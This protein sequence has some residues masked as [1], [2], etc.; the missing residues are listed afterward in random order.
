MTDNEKPLDFAAELQK[1]Y[2][3]RGKELKRSGKKITMLVDMFS[4]D[5]LL[6]FVANLLAEG[7]SMT[8]AR[9]AINALLPDPTRCPA[10][11]RSKYDLTGIRILHPQF[12]RAVG[13]NLQDRVARPDCSEVFKKAL[14]EMGRR[15]TAAKLNHANRR[16]KKGEQQ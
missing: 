5:A 11:F 4:N 14:A 7:G 13:K 16:N 15:S 12:L 6:L 8:R 10:E 2:E 1:E 3:R 9:A